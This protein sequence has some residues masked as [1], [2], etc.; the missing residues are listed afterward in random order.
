MRALIAPQASGGACVH[1]SMRTL[2]A[3]AVA[4]CFPAAAFADAPPPGATWT[5][6]TIKEA[7][8]TRLHADVLRPAG[9]PADARTPVILSIGPYFNH[10]GQTGPAGPI[11]GTPYTPTGEAG[12]SARFY[13]FIN[14]AKLMER[15][16]TWVQVDLRGVGGSSGC[17]DWVG[18]GEQAG[19]R[20]GVGWA[21]KQPWAPGRVGMYGKS[22][23]GVT[24]LVGI[25]QQPQGLAAVVAGE[26][27]YD[28]YRYL[29]SN[30]VR[31]SNSLLT[32]AL[33]DAI[34]GTPGETGD[35]PGYIADSLNDTARPGCPALNWADQ[36]DSNHSSAYWKARDLIAKTKGKTT[37]L[38]LTQG[39]IE[40]NTKPD[41]T[42]DFFNGMAGPKR[43]WFGMWDHVRGNDTDESGRLAMGRAGWFDEVMRFFDKYVKGA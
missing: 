17:P 31:F 27:V 4:L 40:N 35:D 32:P 29:Y 43:A 2:L 18:A 37:P 5:Q 15:G 24:G 39:F 1:V 9:L 42:W 16:Y 12:P 41:G 23:D 33:Y 3:L 19:V 34:A 22:Y 36:Q 7:D 28:L 21:A 13:D 11:E 38:F 14:G 25:A 6:A 8:G 10:S 26:P 20:A 30:R